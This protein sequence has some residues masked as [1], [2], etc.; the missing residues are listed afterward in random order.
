[1]TTKNGMH[2]RHGNEC[3][4]HW[5]LVNATPLATAPHT[6]PRVFPESLGQPAMLFWTAHDEILAEATGVPPGC[7]LL[8]RTT[9]CGVQQADSS[10]RAPKPNYP[11]HPPP[12]HRPRRS[13]HGFRP[14]E[15]R[16][17]ISHDEYQ[18]RKNMES[19]VTGLHRGHVRITVQD[20]RDTRA[21]SRDDKHR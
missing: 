12:C 10:H 1:M 7:L 3:G 6:G 11:R 17:G 8:Y 21:P 14:A 13:A 18:R 15:V 5:T 2:T 4:R 20:P 19:T 9:K 16:S